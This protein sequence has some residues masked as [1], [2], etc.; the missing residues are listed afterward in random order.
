MK[1]CQRIHVSLLKI[2]NRSYVISTDLNIP[3]GGAEGVIVSHGVNF[4]ER[5]E[6]EAAILKTLE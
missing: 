5:T 4:Q 6:L 3:K 2:Y 1:K